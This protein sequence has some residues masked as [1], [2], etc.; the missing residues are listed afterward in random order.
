MRGFTDT[1]SLMA[2]VG[3]HPLYHALFLIGIVILFIIPLAMFVEIVDPN[4]CHLLIGWVQ[5]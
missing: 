2:F 1:I 3:V 5:T 4:I